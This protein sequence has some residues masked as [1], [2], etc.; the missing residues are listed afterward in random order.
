[1]QDNLVTTA[2]TSRQLSQMGLWLAVLIAV[3]ASPVVAAAGSSHLDRAI[4]YYDA[5]EYSRAAELLEGVV[6]QTPSSEAYHW[7]GKSYGHMAEKAALFRALE[8]ARMTRKALEKAVELDAD[9]RP[10][11]EDLMEFYRQAPPIAGGSAEQAARLKKRLTA[12]EQ[13]S[14]RDQNYRTAVESGS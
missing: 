5:A 2:S 12:M 4:E 10:A 14:G 13:N 3:L 1:M 7:L 6:A 9:N 8:L 11:V